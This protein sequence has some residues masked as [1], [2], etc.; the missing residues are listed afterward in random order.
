LAS[1]PVC[2]HGE[3]GGLSA[4]CTPY[5]TPYGFPFHTYGISS[6]YETFLEAVKAAKANEDERA[7]GLLDKSEQAIEEVV[8]IFGEP[9]TIYCSDYPSGLQAQAWGMTFVV[10]CGKALIYPPVNPSLTVETRSR[11]GQFEYAKPLNS[12]LTADYLEIT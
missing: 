12:L 9:S 2:L 5:I 7:L 10:A 6:D 4:V 1:C 11:R 8:S 3:R